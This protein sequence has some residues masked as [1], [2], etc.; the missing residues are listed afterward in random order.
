LL[1]LPVLAAAAA[2][3]DGAGSHTLAILPE[4]PVINVPPQ[5]A[6]RH[7]FQLPSLDYLFRVEARCHSDWKPESLSLNVAD[8]R[9]LRSAAELAENAEQEL[10]MQVPANQLAPL[11]MR[12]FC[13]IEEVE[14]GSG[15]DEG[16]AETTT[17]AVPDRRPA[18]QPT[19]R[20]LTISA[21]LSA[22]ASLRCSNGEE[23]KT[24]YVSQPLDVT[25]LCE[26][27][28]P[29]GAMTTN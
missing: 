26:L 3:A 20:E 29:A 22:H 9:L 5:P 17:A 1:L 8:S 6:Q 14:E 23:Q 27:P 13:V 16:S 24:V 7:L 2:V 12:D 25:L 10:E 21:A 11:A 4:V 15:A 19:P 18:R 28:P